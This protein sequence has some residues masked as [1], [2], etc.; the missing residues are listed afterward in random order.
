MRLPVEVT[1][2]TSA[3]KEWTETSTTDKVTVCGIGF[4]LSRPVEPKR[5][6]HLKLKMPKKFRLFDHARED[7]E[8]WGL[9]RYVLTVQS[10][11]LGDSVRLLVGA[12]LVGESPPESFLEDPKTLYDL[13]PTLK[14]NGFWDFRQLPRRTGRFARVLEDRRASQK[15]AVLQIIDEEGRIVE[16]VSGKTVNISES[17]AAVRVELKTFIPEFVC[18]KP[19]KGNANPL[20]AVVRGSHKLDE[21]PTYRLH[22]EFISGKWTFEK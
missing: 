15:D 16:T 7:Y 13:K 2:R 12:A 21:T 5:L 17:G 18:I 6:V 1:Y 20:L 10:G 22:L 14:Q 19:V 8:V 11:A 9:V 3:E 4:F